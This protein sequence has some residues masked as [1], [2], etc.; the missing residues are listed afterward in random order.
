MTGEYH[1]EGLGETKSERKDKLIALLKQVFP[2]QQ[3]EKWHNLPLFVATTGQG[4]LAGF[5][6]AEKNELKQLRHELFQL[7]LIV[8]PPH[9]LKGV[10]SNLIKF[11]FEDLERN[12]NDPGCMGVYCWVLDS[13]IKAKKNEAIWP[14]TQLVYLGNS[15]D[16]HHLR[17]RYFKRAMI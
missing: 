15:P 4:Q 8:L 13:A 2:N 11:A 14:N 16:G 9:R 3:M 6:L 7:H 12:N 1:F 5:L 17:V 10:A